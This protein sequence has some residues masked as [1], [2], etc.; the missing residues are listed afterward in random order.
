MRVRSVLV[1][2]I[3]P[4]ASERSTR[5]VRSRTPVLFALVYVIGLV[6]VVSA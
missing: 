6:V 1:R 4:R 2:L 5:I 3:R